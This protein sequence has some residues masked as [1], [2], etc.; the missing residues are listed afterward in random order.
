MMASV[1]VLLKRIAYEHN[2]SVLV[3][4][5]YYFQFF[6]MIYLYLVFQKFVYIY[7]H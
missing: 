3:I 7:L 2:V 4:T 5:I 6:H 1:G